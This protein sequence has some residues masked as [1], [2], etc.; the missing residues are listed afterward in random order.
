MAKDFN[1]TPAA[2]KWLR[3]LETT[4]L[5]QGKTKLGNAKEGFCCLGIA[6][7]MLGEKHFGEDTVL[8][9][10]TMNKLGLRH[11]GGSPTASSGRNVKLP[12]CTTMNDNLGWSFKGIAEHLRKYAKYY[13][14]E[15]KRL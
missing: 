8:S 10:E 13:F 4:K 9:F 5:K 2:R 7:R 6:M 12:S 15:A 1:F 11:W 3:E 14:K